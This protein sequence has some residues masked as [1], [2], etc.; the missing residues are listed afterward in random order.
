MKKNYA[1]LSFVAMLFVVWSCK[2]MDNLDPV[3]NWELTTPII[4]TPSDNATLVLNQ[5][6]PTEQIRFEWQAAVSSER[7]QVRYTFVLD[8]ADNPDFSSPILSMT[9]GGSGK[10]LFVAPTARQIDQ[11]LSAAG[12]E[13]NTTA[14]LKWAVMA[15]SLDKVSVASQAVRITRFE[16]ESAPAQLYV[17]GSATE[18][19]ANVTLAIPMKA[20]KDGDG[21]LTGIYELYTGLTAGGTLQF[22]GAQSASAVSFGGASGQLQRNGAAIASPGAG[23]YRITADFNNN[24]YSFLKIDKISVVG[25]NITNGWGGDEPLQYKGN[26]VWEGSVN[27]VADAGYIFRVNGDWAYQ[28]KRI[29]GT[30]NQLVMQSFAEENKIT[31]ED[32]P[33]AGGTG[34]YKFTINFAADKYT[35]AVEKDNSVT[36]PTEVPNQLFLLSDGAKVVELTKSGSTFS[37]GKYLALQKSKTYTLNTKE[38]GSGT[39]YT[40]TGTIGEAATP[41]ADKVENKV[42]VGV[43][44][45]AINV[46]RDQAYQLSVNFSNAELAWKYYN[47][48]LFHWSTAEGGW[49]ARTET[50]MTY[51]HPYKFEVTTNLQKDFITKFN[52]PWDVQF[53]TNGTA[54]SGTM[55]NGGEDFKGISA[56]GSYMATIEIEPDYASATYQ[57]VKQ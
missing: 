52:S 20:L 22:Y 11:A 37:S 21:N 55:T 16:T 12:Y 57:F 47:L 45:T 2:E 35:Y 41:T 9:S 13:A 40:I 6:E 18:K 28:I 42:Q 49:D 50:P 8:S 53:G 17:S 15:Q 5:D 10:N 38:D 33:A 34:K 48:K 25:G 29:V 4:S 14:N 19:G 56:S 30:T 36:P 39:A 44:N 31:F 43:G 3:G 1:L 32:L 26:S 23:A 46:A 51:V 54:L 27:L 24:T 7:Y